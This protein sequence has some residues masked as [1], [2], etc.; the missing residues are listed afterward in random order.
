MSELDASREA[1]EPVERLFRDQ[2]AVQRLHPGASLAVWRRGRL[3]LDL[4]A[5]LADTQQGTPV[6]PDTLFVLFSSTK[7]LASVAVLQLVERGLLDLDE[8]VAKCWP[9]FARNGK[10][11]VTVRHVLTHR[12]GFP[13]TPPLAA[14]KWTDWPAVIAAMEDITPRFRPGTVSAYHAINHG[15]VCAELVHRVDGRPFPR[16]L[17]EEITG[18]L[19]MHDTYAGLPDAALVG[20]IARVHATEDTDDFWLGRTF[21]R[22]DVLQSTTPAA[23]GVSTARDM[24]RFYGALLGGGSLDGATIL[25]PETIA[26]ATAVEIDA[27]LDH[28]LGLEMRRGLGFNL[29][30]MAGSNLRFGSQ[31]TERTFGHGGAGTSICWADKDLDAAMVFI[32]NGFRSEATNVPRSRALSDA[33]R[34]ACIALDHAGA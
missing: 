23:N 25:R 27:E 21:N 28:S 13:E 17:R 18:P 12:G 29:G 15:W 8:P 20:R 4:H 24:A 9:G 6:S 30:G 3:I 26:R 14:S 10:H 2:M 31:T 16:Y 1:F 34:K 11:T 22:A 7:P 5:G 19:G 33:V 32:P